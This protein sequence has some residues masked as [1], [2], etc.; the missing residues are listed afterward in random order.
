MSEDANFASHVDT[1]IGG[2][3]D[4]FLVC[5]GETSVVSKKTPSQVVAL[6]DVPTNAQQTAAI[7]AAVATISIPVTSV[8]GRT[9]AVTLAKSDVGLGNV[10]NTTDSNKPVSTAQAAA[11]ALRVP[12]AGASSAVNLGTNVFTC[13]A[14]TTSGN[15]AVRNGLT[16]MQAEVFS[17]YTSGTAFKS[18]CF[19]ATAS[20]MQIGS[21]RG[22]SD[23][24]TTVQIGHFD[25]AGA[26]TTALTIATNGQITIPQTITLSND[27]NL[28]G[29]T[30][31][32]FSG[33]GVVRWIANGVLRL[34]N[35]AIT[36]GACVDVSTDSVFRIRN[37]GNTADGSV[38]AGDIT[39]SPS[40]SRTLATN[41]QFSIEMTSNT[42]GNLVYR[43]SD[44]TTR[45]MA[46]TFV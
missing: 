8:A 42:A 6:L 41:G 31:L 27:V 28:A 12:Y 44:G 38:V 5:A 29:G 13:G 3:V 18:L 23:T 20:A 36:A 4:T 17:T 19:K 2:T 45:R 9:G 25:A 34:T 46:L 21:A 15:L 40:A 43:G 14:I 7:A 24:N 33:S 26:F 35:S 1:L 39:L 37:R 11:D 30:Q 32:F 22:T 16:A 10:D